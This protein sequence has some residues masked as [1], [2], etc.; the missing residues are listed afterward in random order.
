MAADMPTNLLSLPSEIRNNI[1]EQLLVLQEPVYPFYPWFRLTNLGALTPGLLLVNKTI[2]RETSSLLYA[3]NQFDFAQC[4]S[5][6]VTKFLDQIG[7]NNA[8]YI[9]H[10]YIDFPKFNHLDMNDIILEDDSARILEKIQNDC[11]KLDTLTTSLR[12][13]NDMELK[14]DALDHPKIAVNAIALI[15]A[16]FRTILSLRNIVVEVYEDGPSN[17]IRSAMESHGWTIRTRKNPED[18][19]S[20]RSFTDSDDA[21][22]DYSDDYGYHYDYDDDEYD[23]DFWRRAGD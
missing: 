14:L 19:G 4:T 18:L 23:S 20:Y 13:T 1:Y 11:N 2:H 10:I 7:R 12:S 6:N 22:D 9:R 17:Q 15:N 16:R 21:Y 8:N 3:Q 5:E